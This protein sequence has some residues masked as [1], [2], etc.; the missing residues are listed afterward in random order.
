ML[1]NKWILQK[2]NTNKDGENHDKE[3]NA[4]QKDTGESSPAMK[5]NGK[6][7]VVYWWSTKT[8]KR[9]VLQRCFY[10]HQF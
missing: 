1:Q 10:A 3:R 4:G 7:I 2:K 8:E 6:G 9:V 5:Q